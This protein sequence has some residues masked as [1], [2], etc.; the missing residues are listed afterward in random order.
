MRQIS[1]ALT[2]AQVRAKTKTVTRRTGWTFLKVGTLLQPVAK[3][4]G[5]KKGEHV[6]KIGGPIR[7][8]HVSQEWMS[9][10]VLRHSALDDVRREGFPDMTPEEFVAFFRGSHADPSADDLRVTR[11]EFVY[12]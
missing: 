8:V 7:V 2:T 10:F 5:L 4:Q 9:D 6:E 1:F 11:I 3:A 12:V